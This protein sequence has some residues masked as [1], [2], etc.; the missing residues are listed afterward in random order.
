MED[1]QWVST[2]E[3]LLV[4]FITHANSLFQND[5]VP[6]KEIRHEAHIPRHQ[7][8]SLW[9]DQMQKVLMTKTSDN[10]THVVA[11]D[12]PAAC[13]AHFRFMN[14]FYGSFFI[15]CAE[16]HANFYYILAIWEISMTRGQSPRGPV[17]VAGPCSKEWNVHL[18][19]AGCRFRPTR[20]MP[21]LI[22]W[23]E[24]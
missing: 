21:V 20:E 4:Q 22:Y 23:M 11:G 18:G 7:G 10:M 1:C 3:L 5:R 24:L 6:D 14:L 2:G 17:V 19:S 15:P 16:I 8:G 13:P 12:P 9:E